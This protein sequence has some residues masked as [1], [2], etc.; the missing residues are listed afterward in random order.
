MWKKNLEKLDPTLPV[1]QIT[2]SFLLTPPLQLPLNAQ[3]F[4]AQASIPLMMMTLWHHQGLLA[5]SPPLRGSVRLR[6][7]RQH[8]ISDVWPVSLLCRKR[9]GNRELLCQPVHLQWWVLFFGHPESSL[10]V[11]LQPPKWFYQWLCNSPQPQAVPQACCRVCCWPCPCAWCYWRCWSWCC[12]ST[13]QDKTGGRGRGK[14]T[15]TTSVTTRYGTLRL[16]WSARLFNV[17]VL[18]K[19]KTSKCPSLNWSTAFLQPR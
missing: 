15:T 18:E 3:I 10:P 2:C 8:L 7:D 16:W 19:Q 12:G 9:P 11:L 1:M 14:K 6:P 13:A 17:S 5:L 4:Q